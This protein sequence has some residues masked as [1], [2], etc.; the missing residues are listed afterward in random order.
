MGA[1]LVSIG[2][3]YDGPRGGRTH[4]SPG[5]VALLDTLDGWTVHVPGHPDEVADAAAGRR[6]RQRRSGLPAAVDPE[7][8]AGRTPQAGGLHVVRDAGPGA[9]LLR[10]GRA[11][12]RP[13]AL[14]AIGGPAT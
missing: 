1:V 14:A 3:S 2:A 13:D 5:D 9:A 8:R 4:L 10:R 6:S 11:D 7:Q 12:A